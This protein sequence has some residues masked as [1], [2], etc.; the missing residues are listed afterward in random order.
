VRWFAL[1]Q[2]LAAVAVAVAIVAV[3]L[4]GV[5]AMAE[6]VDESCVLAC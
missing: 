2:F 6:E 3:E 4:V 5:A 1:S